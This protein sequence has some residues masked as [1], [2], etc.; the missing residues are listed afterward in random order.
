MAVVKWSSVGIAI[1]I[2]RLGGK[3]SQTDV[4]GPGHLLCEVGAPGWEGAA[5]AGSVHGLQTCRERSPLTPGHRLISVSR[6]FDPILPVEA[7]RH[8]VAQAPD[9]VAEAPCLVALAARLAGRVET[10]EAAGQQA[11]PELAAPCLAGRAAPSARRAVVRA[12]D[13]AWFVPFNVT[14]S[15]LAN[16]VPAAYLMGCSLLPERPM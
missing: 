10:P 2:G 4:R 3:Q 9:S 15:N 1:G 16:L 12:S 7:G 14:Q 5:L 8:A 11:G 13:R 6:P